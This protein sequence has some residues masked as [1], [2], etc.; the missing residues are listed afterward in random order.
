MTSKDPK[1]RPSA[2]NLLKLPMFAPITT[3]KTSL[4]LNLNARRNSY[5]TGFTL[6]STFDTNRSLSTFRSDQSEEKKQTL[7]NDVLSYRNIMN[8]PIIQRK[9]IRNISRPI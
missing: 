6:Q 3:K 4:L 8:H 7:Q 5:T 2:E 9:V 1:V